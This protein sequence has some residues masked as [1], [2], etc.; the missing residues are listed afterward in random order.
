M[1]QRIFNFSAGPAV[2]P[3]PVLREAQ[4]RH[5][6]LRRHRH[7]HPRAQPPRRRV[8]RRDRRGRGR[9]PRA[10]R[11]PGDYKPCSS[12]SAARRSSSPCCR[13]TCC[14][15]A[16]S[17][18]TSTPA[19]G[20]RRRWPEAR[21][22]GTRARRRVV[23][24]LELHLHPAATEIHWSER[25]AY[26]HFTSN[27]TI[28]GTQWTERAGAAGRRL[29][30]VRRV[31]RHLLAADRRH[32]VRRALRRRAEE[33]RPGGR[34]ARD[35]PRGPAASRPCASCRPCCATAPTPS[36]ARS[37]TRRRPSAST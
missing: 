10:R 36:R 28:F 6:G 19:R 2:L 32:E 35:R 4:P 17:P 22:Y 21:R 9:L 5:L 8:R 26:A 25:P 23:E 15:T 31:E 1:S 18:T 37:T 29:A 20:R 33:P 3:E 34:H 7:R 30:R 14:P 13:R 12:S 27:N 11:H 16:P 24:G